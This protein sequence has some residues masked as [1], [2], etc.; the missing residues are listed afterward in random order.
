LRLFLKGD[1]KLL[2][3]EI[4]EYEGVTIEWI[5]GKK[6][7]LTIFEDGKKKEDVELYNYQ[8]REQM[9]KVMEEKGFHKVS[10][11]QKMAQI[12]AERREA[13]L[14]QVGDGT[15]FYGQLMSVYFLVFAMI[16]GE[17]PN[18]NSINGGVVTIRCLI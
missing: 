16:V 4:T 7:V 12:Q 15:S 11:Q 10:Q 17:F 1:G 6:A 2:K 14:R 9:H 18:G 13:Q 5:R 8:T 3:G